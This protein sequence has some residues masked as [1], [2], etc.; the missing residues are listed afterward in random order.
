MRGRT[1]Q[2]QFTFRE[3]RSFPR[4]PL[5]HIRNREVR[6]GTTIYFVKS[7]VNHHVNRSRKSTL[8]YH[9]TLNIRRYFL[10]RPFIMFSTREVT[11][12]LMD[13]RGARPPLTT[14]MVSRNVLFTSRTTINRPFGSTMVHQF[15]KVIFPVQ[16]A[17]VTPEDLGLRRLFPFLFAYHRGT[18]LFVGIRV[19]WFCRVPLAT[20]WRLHHSGRGP[21]ASPTPKFFF[22]PSEAQRPRFGID[23]GWRP[24]APD[25]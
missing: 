18:L 13:R 1:R 6:R 3:I 9:Q 20:G 23:V 15:M 8:P 4:S 22:E 12:H 25:P 19:R 10:P 2:P 24:L 21:Q 11:T 16:V 17:I 14:T 7:L 5:R